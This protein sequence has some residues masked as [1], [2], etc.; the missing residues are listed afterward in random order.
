MCISPGKRLLLRVEKTIDDD[1]APLGRSL[2]A[3]PRSFAL[4]HTGPGVRGPTLPI[5]EEDFA[6][7][8]NLFRIYSTIALA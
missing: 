8:R 4:D 2:A 6:A 1:C 3:R 7:I 5:V